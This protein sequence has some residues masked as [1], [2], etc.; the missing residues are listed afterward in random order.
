MDDLLSGLL[1]AV[2]GGFMGGIV[3]LVAVGRQIKADH[4]IQQRDELRAIIAQFWRACDALWSAQQDLGW[5]IVEIQINRGVENGGALEHNHK[6]RQEALQAIGHARKDAREAMALLR[7][8]YPKLVPPAEALVSTSG[9][10]TP[11]PD[12]GDMG[13]GFE[14]KR[15]A[16]LDNFETTA[17]AAL[18]PTRAR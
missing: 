1:G 10:F 12:A 2:I 6:A 8:L 3:A 11:R 14:A 16:A 5:A 18:T 17:R 7:L 4:G 13:E 9:Q 15:Q